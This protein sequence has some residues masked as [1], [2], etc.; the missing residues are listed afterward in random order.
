MVRRS[1]TTRWLPAG[2]PGQTGISAGPA[3]GADHV[4]AQPVDRLAQQARDLHLA[5]AEHLGDLRLRAARRRST[6]AA[7]RGRRRRAAPG[8]AAAPVRFSMPTK[9][10]SSAADHLVGL[11]AARRGRVRRARWWRRASS[12]AMASRTSRSS[13]PMKSATSPGDGRSAQVVG[14]QLGGVAGG[15]GQLVHPA[16]HP[17]RPPGVAEVA[18]QRARRSSAWRRPGT[19]VRRTG[20]NRCSARTRAS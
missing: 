1:W 5:A 20:S 14:E 15:A 9:P 7:A 18:A 16:G 8:S 2:R 19:G 3:S 17:D 11:Q 6:S 12:A 13:T 10:R 4:A